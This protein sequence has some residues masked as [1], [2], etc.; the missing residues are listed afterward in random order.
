MLLSLLLL[1]LGDDSSKIPDPDKI[2]RLEEIF[3]I[4]IGLV[5]DRYL[6]RTKE[7]GKRVHFINLKSFTDVRGKSKDP[8]IIGF[9]QWN[10]FDPYWINNLKDE[11]LNSNQTFQNDSTAHDRVPVKDDKV[12][13][14]SDYLITIRGTPFGYS[15][16]NNADVQKFA[17]VP[18][19]HFIRLRPQDED[20]LFLPYFHLLLDHL[21]E[22]GFAKEFNKDVDEKGKK[23]PY[24]HLNSIK[25]EDL[26]AMQINYHSNFEDQQKVYEN[27]REKYDKW[28]QSNLAFYQ[29]QMNFFNKIS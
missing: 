26:K 19:H 16:L 4:R 12:L 14:K 5:K 10:P 29:Y 27:Y 21:V 28:Q 1:Y 20:N 13:L 9:E 7:T 23:M 24:A 3:D 22:F 8:Y 11:A 2:A 6:E 18:T 15:F 25:V 17:F